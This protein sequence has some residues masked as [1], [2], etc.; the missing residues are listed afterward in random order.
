MKDQYVGDLKDYYKYVLLRWLTRDNAIKTSICWMLT[1]PENNAQ[2]MDVEYLVQELFSRKEKNKDD[3][4]YRLIDILRKIVPF[5]L[6][7]EI[8]NQT[9]E[10]ERMRLITE[11]ITKCNVSH[12]ESSEI[13]P[14]AR[15]RYFRTI[16]AVNNDCDLVFLDPDI[17][18][19]GK[20][21]DEIAAKDV[22][23]YLFVDDLKGIYPV[24]SLLIFQY[25]QPKL[26]VKKE[27]RQNIKERLN[28]H[29]YQ[30][31][32]KNLAQLKKELNVE[33]L[34]LFRSPNVLFILL[35]K[36]AH[37]GDS[38]EKTRMIEQRAA[39]FTQTK[40]HQNCEFIM[41]EY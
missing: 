20:S 9:N 11:L 33:K 35:T 19:T 10:K 37:Q 18:L 28:C 23:K 36:S 3:D 27:P 40:W 15:T 26:I 22:S 2:G 4:H 32:K 34:Y 31:I 8:K 21:R 14:A 25:S 1:E 12:I 30:A 41:D 17:G 13:M 5:G 6:K 38:E 7:L 39:E 29:G 16:G 24:C